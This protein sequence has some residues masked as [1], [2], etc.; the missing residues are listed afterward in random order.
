MVRASCPLI[1]KDGQD[2]HPTKVGN[3]FFGVPLEEEFHKIAL[4][5][6]QKII[7]VTVII[8]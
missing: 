2:A 1:I 6:I 5:L 4:I 3:L 8:V 7:Y